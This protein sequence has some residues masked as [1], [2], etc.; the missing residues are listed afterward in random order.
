VSPEGTI[1]Y[2]P[3]RQPPGPSDVTIPR[4]HRPPQRPATPGYVFSMLEGRFPGDFACPTSVRSLSYA[5][6]T[7]GKPL[8]FRPRDTLNT[9]TPGVA[10]EL[11]GCFRGGTVRGGWT[12]GWRP[13]LRPAAP[14]GG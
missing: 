8:D 2:S 14:S 13:R 7:P 12:G 5:C 10:A 1:S 6:Q 4:L 9:Y 3:G 11:A